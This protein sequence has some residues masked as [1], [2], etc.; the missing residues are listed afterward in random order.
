MTTDIKEKNEYIIQELLILESFL[1]SN[2]KD[3]PKRL[4]FGQLFILI[5]DFLIWAPR[6]I[7]FLFRTGVIDRDEK[8]ALKLTITKIKTKHDN[9]FSIIRDKLAAHH[10][11]IEFLSLIDCIFIIQYSIIQILIDDIHNFYNFLKN[12]IN[13]NYSKPI[14][15]TQFK[16]PILDSNADKSYSVS[17]SRLAHSTDD[18]VGM[19]LFH[20]TQEKGSLIVSIIDSLD[21]MIKILNEFETQNAPGR[22]LILGL[23]IN[24]T[25][26]F[27]DNLF[28]NS[29]YDSSLVTIWKKNYYTGVALLE[30]F[31]RN[32]K[33]E[34]ELLYLRNKFC[35]HIDDVELLNSLK[36]KIQ[37]VDINVLLNY[38]EKLINNF[39]KACKMQIQTIMMIFSREPL[40]GVLGL[41]SKEEY[42]PLDDTNYV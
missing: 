34:E 36:I 40:L 5:D 35:S 25:I 16:D 33:R 27:L 2:V 6:S 41:S 4:L 30:S 39:N 14:N 7:N 17:S 37:S 10:Q 1:N 19:I 8:T 15:S 20:E 12:K 3:L 13:L 11:P 18:I 29:Q 28:N 22:N 32:E 42:K 24:N 23:I 26:S 31:E 21:Y 9:N 38:I